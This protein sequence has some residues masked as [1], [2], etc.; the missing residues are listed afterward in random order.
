MLRGRIGDIDR[1]I[2]GQPSAYEVGSLLTTIDGTGPTTAARLIAE[3]GDSA[4]FASA[5]ALAAYVGVSPGLKQ[6]RA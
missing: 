3:L 1:D 6:S 2:A 5:A 4:D